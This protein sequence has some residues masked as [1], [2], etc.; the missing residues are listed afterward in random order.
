MQFPGTQPKTILQA[1]ATMLWLAGMAGAQLPALCNTGHD[2]ATAFGC[3]GGLVP[4]NPAGGGPNR[5]GNWH[6]AYPYPSSLAAVHAPCR[7]KGFLKAWVDTPNSAWLPDSVS[8]T[9]E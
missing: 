9:S 4:P 7:L 1:L 6:L 8:M 5:D 3:T 2:T